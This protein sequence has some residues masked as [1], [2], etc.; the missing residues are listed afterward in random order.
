MLTTKHSP[1]YKATKWEKF[2]NNLHEHYNNDIPENRNLSINKID[3]NIN[4]I[5]KAILTLIS[6]TI[7][8]INPFRN[9][10]K[11]TTNKIRKLQKYKNYL[12][13]LRHDLHISD[14][15]SRRRVTKTAT[16]AFKTKTQ[17][18]HDNFKLS[19]EK[20]WVKQFEN[21]DCHK[22]VVFLLKINS[23]FRAKPFNNIP[24]L[25]IPQNNLD[26]LNWGKCNLTE[27]QK[28]NNTL[29]FST[30]QEKFNIIEAYSEA[31]N[32]PRH[33]NSNSRLKQ[34]VDDTADKFKTDFINLKDQNH[35]TI[36]FKKDKD[37]TNPASCRPI[38]KQ[39]PKWLILLIWDMI[40]GIS[41]LIWNSSTLSFEKF[42]AVEG[43]FQSTV[44]SPILFLIFL[45]DVTSL[46]NLNK[47]SGTSFNIG[48][49]VNKINNYYFTTLRPKQ[50]APN[51]KFRP[52][53]LVPTP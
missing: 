31:I 1:N 45:S 42:S 36:P 22:P 40:E 48:D 13:S 37:P 9:I 32:S 20:Y 7:P 53:Y 5:N 25:Y 14:P 23:L 51:S 50:G 52:P 8:K 41:F 35:S 49:P 34:L 43:L 16:A 11:Y 29:I 38:E 47:E 28:S 12:V 46:F 19:T 2:T 39:F 4:K 26:L 15:N 17:K 21:V 18:L 3:E 6:L 27:A 44:N 24:E 30:P 10:L 33:L